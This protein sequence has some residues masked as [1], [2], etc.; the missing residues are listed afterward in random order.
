[1]ANSNSAKP[2]AP[3]V[4]AECSL[5]GPEPVGPCLLGCGFLVK[6]LNV[7]SES[8]KFFRDASEVGSRS[9]D[10]PL[11]G[12][13]IVV[14]WVGRRLT[15]RVNGYETSEQHQNVAGSL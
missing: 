11:D 2:S 4:H 5:T 1:M 7:G 10:V 14:R 13:E 12:C 8:T 6:L 15:D 9:R 3:K